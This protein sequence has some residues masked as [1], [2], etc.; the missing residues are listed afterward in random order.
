MHAQKNACKHFSKNAGERVKRV[1]TDTTLATGTSD[2]AVMLRAMIARAH[3]AAVAVFD[4]KVN[5]GPAITMAAPEVS[6]TCGHEPCQSSTL[7][8]RRVGDTS[9]VDNS[10]ARNLLLIIQL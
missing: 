9:A 4:K 10:A 7:S 8:A 3:A 1:T 6:P 2:P 5:T